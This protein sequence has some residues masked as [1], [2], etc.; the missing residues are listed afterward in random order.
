MDA[1][2]FSRITVPDLIAQSRERSAGPAQAGD[3]AGLLKEGVERLDSLQ[4]DAADQARRLMA[5]EPIEL[6]RVVLAAEE[7]SLAFDLAL[8]VRNKVVEAYQEIMRMQV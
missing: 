2:G 7:A 6:H 1:L 8:N 5:G 3:F 4:S